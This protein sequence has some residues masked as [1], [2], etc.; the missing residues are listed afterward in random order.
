VS[1]QN[2]VSFFLSEKTGVTHMTLD[3]RARVNNLGAT[4]KWPV[5]GQ[6][7]TELR[8][9]L[10]PGS[11]DATEFMTAVHHVLTSRLPF[12]LTVE[13]NK[14]IVSGTWLIKNLSSNESTAHTSEISLGLIPADDHTPTIRPGPRSFP[15]LWG[16]RRVVAQVTRGESLQVVVFQVLEPHSE[17]PLLMSVP[18]HLVAPEQP[19]L[20]LQRDLV[21]VRAQQFTARAHRIFDMLFKFQDVADPDDCVLAITALLHKAYAAA[22]RGVSAR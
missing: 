21:R 17:R 11:H 3:R 1:D 15:D 12:E 14:L 7:E 5:P 8:I 2:V 20:E 19:S 4:P 9:S 18:V 13:H 22:T 10:F 6:L 16:R